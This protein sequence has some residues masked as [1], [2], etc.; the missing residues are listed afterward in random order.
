LGAP[1][2]T[3][4]LADTANA[5]QT[6]RIGAA[7][8]EALT[9]YFA[10]SS[11]DIA[12][13]DIYPGARRFRFTG[14][15][16]PPINVWLYRPRSAGANAP[17][18]F[19][20]HGVRRDADRYLREWGPLADANSAVLVVPEFSAEAFP[21]AASYNLGAALDAADAPRP[22]AAW[23][24]SAIEAVF[25]EIVAREQLSAER[26]LLYGHS[27]GGQ[28][29]HRYV[30]LGAGPRLARAVAANA[31]WYTFPTPDVP[32]P[33]G[34]GGGPAAAPAAT[35][36]STPLFLLLGDQ[37][38]DPNHPSLSREPGAMAQGEHRFERGQAFYAAA[39]DEA[40]SE[41]VR[42]GW[43]CLR[44]PGL[45]H[46][47]ALAARYAARVLFTTQP[48]TPGTTCQTLPSLAAH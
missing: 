30:M 36:F 3:L 38:I 44:A 10:S 21:G 37:D 48:A 27:A 17:V 41:G 31:G 12:R 4:E 39:R 22:R 16:G 9:D 7:T 25:D 46:D 14:W 26:Y 8:A 29:V 11:A 43:S 20:M 2:I 35:M 1:G 33:H 45:A 47:N 18:F 32:W 34:L 5:E 28:F 6:Q 42:L 19:V 23:T 13:D 15:A 24:Y 40:R